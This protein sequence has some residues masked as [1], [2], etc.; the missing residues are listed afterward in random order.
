MRALTLA[1]AGGV[2]VGDDVELAD[3]VDAEEL[4]AGAAGGDVDER[5]SG[6]L[7]AVEE[8]EIVLRAAAGDGEHV[9]DGGVGRADG[10]GALAGVV[11][12]RGIEGD[13]LVVAAAV[14]GELLDLALVDEAGGLLGGEVDDGWRVVDG[15]LL[16]DCV[17][18]EGDV[19]PV[20]W[21]TVRGIRCA[22]CGA[23]PS[24]SAVT[25]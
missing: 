17:D 16:I 25:V 21:P 24:A 22:C 3:G 18:G 12:G 15:D 4:A 9:A 5:G 13:E 11:D 1:V 10:A 19:D 6:V 2:G 8:E 7:D 20:L 23:K 14:E